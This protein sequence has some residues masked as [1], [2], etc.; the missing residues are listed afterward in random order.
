MKMPI[1]ATA[2]VASGGAATVTGVRKNAKVSAFRPK[3]PLILPQPNLAQPMTKVPRLVLC[4]SLKQTGFTATATAGQDCM[5][6]PRPE[7]PASPR[8]GTN[9]RASESIVHPDQSFTLKK[10]E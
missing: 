10:C 5:T 2:G 6:P 3:M 1:C 9:N 4:V 8:S 7:A